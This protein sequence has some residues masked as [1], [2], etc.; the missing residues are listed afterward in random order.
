MERSVWFCFSSPLCLP[1]CVSEVPVGNQEL[2]RN[3]A[4]NSLVPAGFEKYLLFQTVPWS[5]RYECEVELIVL[6]I[7]HLYT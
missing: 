7:V 2:Y 1:V 3:P 5:C 4:G 6:Y